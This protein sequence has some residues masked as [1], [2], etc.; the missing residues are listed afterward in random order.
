MATIIEMPKLS[1][2]MTE[3]T[4]VRWL[5]QIGD[6]IEVGDEIAEIET[7]KATMSMEAFD[8]GILHELYVQE[9]EKVPLGGRLALLLDEGEDPPAPGDDLSAAIPSASGPAESAP[10]SSVE[11]SRTPAVQSAAAPGDGRRIAAS[12]LARRMA[13]E[14]GVDLRQIKGSGPG[15]RIVGRDVEHAPTVR[16]KKVTARPAPAIRPAAG[17]GHQRIPLTAMRAVIAERLLASKT[18][19]PHFYLNIDVDAGPLLNLRLQVNDAAERNQ[20]A[21]KYTINDFILKGV[22]QSAVAVPEV[23]ASFDG[24][25]IVRFASVNVSVA[26]AIE[27]GLVTPVIRDAQ[28]KSLLEISQSVKDLASRARA[29]KLSPDEFSGGTL[30]VSNLGAHG[31]DSFDAIINPPQACIIGTGTIRK[32]PVVNADDEIVIGHRLAVSMSCDHRVIDG[33]V[34]ARYLAEFRRL[35]ENPALMLL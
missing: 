5:K 26:V 19:I 34:G 8:E 27:D 4:L 2:T 1:D 20:S 29:K 15:G 22:I 17:A 9:G 30:T 7:D 33:A 18:Q 23:N 11:S 12:P 31:I 10:E 16:S 28:E 32:A 24:D 25:A 3:G 35:I 6:S 14:R 21:N 13:A